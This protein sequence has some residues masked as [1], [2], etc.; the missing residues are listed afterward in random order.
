M[1][2][3]EELFKLGEWFKAN[4]LS[5]NLSKTKWTLFH[6]HDKKRFIPEILPQIIIDKTLIQRDKVTKFLG[7]YVD[8][9]LTWKAHIECIDNKIS[10][11]IGIL[12]R[13]RHILNKHQLKLI[14]FSFIHSYLTYTNIAWASTNKSKLMLLYRRQKHAI[15]VINFKDRFTHTQPLFAE[16]KILS[17]YELNIFQTICFMFKCREGTSPN[18]FHNLYTIKPRNKYNMR[19]E[20]TL[21]EPLKR[22]TLGQFDITFRGPHLW[23]KLLS[24]NLELTQIENFISFK[25]KLKEFLLNEECTFA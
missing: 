11:S 9:N 16:M 18:I 12:Y 17:I 10:K 8:E 13:S 6:P 7:V 19:S 20:M 24:T 2:M 5:L 14:Y 3:N 23:N 15:R 25:I 4:K 22:T 1:V 21:V